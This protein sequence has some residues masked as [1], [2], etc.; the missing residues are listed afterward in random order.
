MNELL[1]LENPLFSTY[2][3]CASIMILKALSMS[4]FTVIRMMQ[5]KGGYL[6]QEDL[7][8]TPLNPNPSPKQIAPNERVER[9]RRM[10][11]NDLESIPFFL[12]AGF[13][14]LFTNPSLWLTRTLFYGYVITRFLHFF[15]Y[16]SARTHDLRAMLWTPGSLIL[17]FLSAR[18]L[19]AA[20][21]ICFSCH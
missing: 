17:I 15:A 5:E 10:H 8:K 9:T 14:Y 18:T 12:A 13:L 11:M 6:E 16:A 19:I 4:W 3:I 7:K 1:T 2:V 20:L 21:G